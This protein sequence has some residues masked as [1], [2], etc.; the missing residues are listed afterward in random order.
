[1]LVQEGRHVS[2]SRLVAADRECGE[3][4]P[5]E[6]ELQ[7]FLGKLQTIEHPGICVALRIGD[8]VL[9]GGPGPP[10]K[11]GGRL[12]SPTVLCDASYP[13]KVVFCRTR[14]DRLVEAV[15][16]S[17]AVYQVWAARSDI[18]RFAFGS[19]GDPGG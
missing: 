18:L 2:G 16:H 19:V 13:V 6:R 11:L 15:Q 17:T 12:G 10:G 7:P 5:K 4:S 8:L 1:M 3:L 9:I 14:G